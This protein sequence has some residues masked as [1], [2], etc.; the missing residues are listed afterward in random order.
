MELGRFLLRSIDQLGFH[1]GG[2]P[3]HAKSPGHSSTS[4]RSQVAVKVGKSYTC[5]LSERGLTSSR[6]YGNVTKSH[7]IIRTTR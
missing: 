7:E 4:G 2:S 5:A 6:F 1:L 3:I